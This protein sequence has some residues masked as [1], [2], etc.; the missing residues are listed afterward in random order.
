[1]P[2]IPLNFRIS[3]DVYQE[4]IKR[5]LPGETPS[6]VAQRLLLVELTGSAEKNMGIGG[7]PPELRN[8]IIKNKNR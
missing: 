2:G 3:P 7:R 8:V 5:A 6:L 4:L 1:M